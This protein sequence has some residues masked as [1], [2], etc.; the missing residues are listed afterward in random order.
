MTVADIVLGPIVLDLLLAVGAMVLFAFDLLAGG[1][2]GSSERRSS[3]ALGYFAAALFAI[4]LAATFYVDASGEAFGGAYVGGEWPLFFKRLFYL[5]GA[6]TCLGG[7]DHVARNTPH[8]QGEYYLLLAFSV[9]GMSLLA[10]ARDLI[11]LVVCLELMGIPLYALAAFAKTDDKTGRG[12]NAAEAG[13]KLYLVGAVSS[14]VTLFGLSWIVTATGSTDIATIAERGADHQLITTGTLL[15][16]CGL[17]FKIGAVPFH[18]WVPDTYQGAPTPFVA[19]LSVAP[20]VAGFAALGTLLQLGLAAQMERWAPTVLVVTVV[21]LV[22]G[23]LLALPQS[24]V[25]RLLAY[26]GIAQIGYMLMAFL[27]ADAYGSGMLLF[28][29]LSYLFT[30]V[31]VFLVVEAVAAST[32]GDDAVLDFAGLYRRAPWLALAMLVFLLSLAGIP[33]VSGFWAKLYV[34]LAAW[35]GGYEWLVLLGALLAVVGLFYYLRV[36]RAMYMAEPSTE[37]PVEVGHGMRIAILVCLLAVVGMGIGPGYVYPVAVTAAQDL[38]G[39]A[40]AATPP[41]PATTE[42]H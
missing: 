37:A 17:G 39:L 33:F 5:A 7:A 2:E 32:P 6:L 34:F 29:M 14:V 38:A 11:L 18:F 23:N 9:L 19:F 28:Y 36:A 13:L 3:P 31:G 8:R 25:K 30:N 20:K 4:P 21:T 40:P 42:D 1:D 16:L 41:P 15:L 35:R 24:H 26:S 10:G 27:V 12:R 22:L